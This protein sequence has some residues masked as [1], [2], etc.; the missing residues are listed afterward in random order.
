MSQTALPLSNMKL[1]HYSDVRLHKPCGKLPEINTEFE[2]IIKDMF[3]LTKE[4]K[5]LGLAAPQIGLEQRFFIINHGG[6]KIVCID[7]EIISFSKQVIVLEEGC[8]TYPD[9]YLNITRPMGV[10]VIYTDIKGK[11]VKTRFHE[12]KS[13]IF[14]HEFDHLCGITFFDRAQ[15]EVKFNAGVA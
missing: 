1:I 14:Q 15:S 12:M 11:R 8:L 7:P 3:K 13:R 10:K 2:S 5:G 9:Q 6:Q 4:Q